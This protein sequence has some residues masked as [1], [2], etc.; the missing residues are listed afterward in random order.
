LQKETNNVE[1]L[2]EF[3]R[4]TLKNVLRT[5]G[6]IQ[7][8]RDHVF[9]TPDGFILPDKT[10]QN[11]LVNTDG[12]AVWF[13]TTINDLIHSLTTTS[14][15]K[16]NS[17]WSEAVATKLNDRKCGK[18]K[19]TDS[20][21][22]PI[23]LEAIDNIKQ[24]TKTTSGGKIKYLQRDNI[25]NNIGS[26]M[27]FRG[28]LADGSDGRTVSVRR[29]CVPENNNKVGAIKV[30]DRAR[31]KMKAMGIC[32]HENLIKYYDSEYDIVDGYF[33]IVM[34]PCLVT[35]EDYVL[36][37]KFFRFRNIAGNGIRRSDYRLEIVDVLEQTTN[38]L[39]YLHT[40]SKAGK[41]GFKIDLNPQNIFI[42]EI[43]EGSRLKVVLADFEFSSDLILSREK[44]NYT[45]IHYTQDELNWRVPDE[46]LNKSSDIFTLALMMHFC[47]YGKATNH[48]DIE[49]NMKLDL[50]QRFLR[51][52]W[53]STE[54]SRTKLN[55]SDCL[56]VE[57]LVKRMLQV[58]SEKRPTSKSVLS[59]L[60]FWNSSKKL[61]FLAAVNK[62]LNTLTVKPQDSDFDE[63]RVPER[64]GCLAG[65]LGTP[66]QT[67][68]LKGPELIR[69]QINTD[70]TSK[71]VSI[72][73]WQKKNWRKFYYT[74]K[75]LSQ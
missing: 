9:E 72:G 20:D 14:D 47:V 56:E 66:K 39:N 53:R 7:I 71:T 10:H 32:D 42:C 5:C 30:L 8:I 52:N 16:I 11:K 58:E 38:G 54:T 48:K 68:N 75:I 41:F 59:H 22:L 64:Q 31:A 13:L 62:N 28:K 2:I 29:I 61:R 67:N 44:E 19:E 73:N 60:L 25:C 4:K 15:H 43:D 12:M 55:F 46:D 63:K 65:G 50:G 17:E 40:T 49:L 33:Y 34:P 74:A 3:D 27:V 57:H 69:T 45:Q 6:T 18:N 35:L 1:A 37:R 21:G 51:N 23:A 70:L 24:R 36:N 26:N